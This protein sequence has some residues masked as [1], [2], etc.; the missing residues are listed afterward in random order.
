M[1]APWKS[2]S[3]I[4]PPFVLASS[5]GGTIKLADFAGKQEVVLLFYPMDFTP[6]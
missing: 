6:T 3:F 2:A 1:P 5:K 4:V